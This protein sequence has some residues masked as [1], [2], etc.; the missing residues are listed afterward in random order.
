[1]RYARLIPTL[2]AAG[3]CLATLG[4]TVADASAP[5]A[6][7][8]PPAGYRV[9][10]SPQLPSPNNSDTRGSVR[11]PT[12]TVPLGGGVIAQS[13]SIRANVASSFPS[14]RSW[15]GD[16]KNGSGTATTFQVE[17][18]CAKRPKGYTVVRSPNAVNRSGSQTRSVATCPAGTKPLGGGGISIDSSV[19]VDMHSTGPH[20]RTWAVKENNAG[21]FD[22]GLNAVAVCGK[23]NGY[24]VVKGLP[25]TIP[26]A[27]QKGA[28]AVCRA[29][30]VPISGGVL[31]PSTSVA[32]NIG[33]SIPSGDRWDS[34]VT[35]NTGFDATATPVV[36]CATR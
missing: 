4:V 1:M 9:V 24:R 33:G 19:F 13:P 31:S 3:V 36:V 18:I 17:V 11:C 35:N 7:P 29:P 12:G 27:G 34:F 10:I 32:V 21:P 26:A 5:A 15:F 28:S 14:G 6:K 2:A 23:V 16:V 30:S 22:S 25:F 8:K 20:G